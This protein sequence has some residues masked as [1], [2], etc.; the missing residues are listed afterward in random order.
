MS[1]YDNYGTTMFSI[2]PERKKQEVLEKLHKIEKSVKH[3]GIEKAE[4]VSYPL[5]E[6]WDIA[7][8]LKD[9]AGVGAPA[10]AQVGKA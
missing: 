2:L 3:A 8:Q 9:L 10:D 5:S 1:I 6:S 7:C 4:R